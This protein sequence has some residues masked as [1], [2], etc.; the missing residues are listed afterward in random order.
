[1]G[2][3]MKTM[4]RLLTV[5]LMTAIVLWPIAAA[6][7]PWVAYLSGLNTSDPSYGAVL[8]FVFLFLS[9]PAAGVIGVV[10]L[11]VERIVGLI[12]RRRVRHL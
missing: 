5:I 12:Y 2:V 4:L 11:V 7:Y 1:M 8:P 9:L 10:W 6:K 3:K